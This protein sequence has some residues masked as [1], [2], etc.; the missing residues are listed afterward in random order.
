MEITIS[1]VT[2]N[3]IDTIS[4][5]IQSIYRYSMRPGMH[6]FVIDNGSKDGTREWIR[7]NHPDIRLIE[8]TVNVGFGNAH[9]QLLPFLEDG[10]CFVVN[11]DIELE[12]DV[13]GPIVSYMERNPDIHMITPEIQNPDGSIQHL[14]KCDPT[15]RY[16][17]VSKLPMFHYLRRR[18]TRQNEALKAPTDIE[19][20]TGCFFCIRSHTYVEVGGF[21]KAYFMY[22][23]DADLS[24][25]VRTK[26]EHICYYPLVSVQHKWHRENIRS[27]RG[28]MRYLRSMILYF[29]RWGWRL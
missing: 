6:F 15:L 26:G 19:F 25:K 23:E 16:L 1:I 9:N 17:L 11:P 12:K 18:Y 29:N 8:N 22:F 28:I 14:P 2:Y 3:N 20:C 21:E 4:R 27:V 13:I 10:Y 5:C 24:R 7:E